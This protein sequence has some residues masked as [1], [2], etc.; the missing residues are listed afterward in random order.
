MWKW[1]RKMD[2]RQR[3]KRREQFEMKKQKWWLLMIV[4]V[5]EQHFDSPFYVVQEV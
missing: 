2:G 3:E 4:V 5:L 1:A